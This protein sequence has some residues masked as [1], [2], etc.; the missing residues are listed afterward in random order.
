MVNKTVFFK[1]TLFTSS[2]P[3]EELLLYSDSI[4]R[5][6]ET[7]LSMPSE[8]KCCNASSSINMFD[9]TF[10][11]RAETSAYAKAKPMASLR[12]SPPE[13][14]RKERSYCSPEC[15][16]RA[17]MTLSIFS[18]CVVF[19]ATSSIESSSKS[20]SESLYVMILLFSAAED[21][22][23]EELLLTSCKLNAPPVNANTYSWH[24]SETSAKTFSN[25]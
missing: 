15:C 5:N 18:N 24:L 3:L 6:T 1:R 20:S 21:D 9:C 22:E 11:R 17:N 23:K 14:C 7:T 8:S 12:R 2:Q 4:A 10:N 19:V 25:K 16:L 13:S